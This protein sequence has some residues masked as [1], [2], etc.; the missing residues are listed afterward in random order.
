MK[1]PKISDKLWVANRINTLRKNKTLDVSYHL[2][3]QLESEGFIEP[4]MVRG[5]TGRL[6]KS[7]VPSQKGIK[8]LD[9]I[10]KFN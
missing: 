5:E 3:R 7:Y 8:L 2:A 10:Q 4:T 6:H 9:T 1:T